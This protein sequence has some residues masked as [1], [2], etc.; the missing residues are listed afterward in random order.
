MKKH[1][2]KKVL[3]FYDQIEQVIMLYGNDDTKDKLD[4]VK[5]FIKENFQIEEFDNSYLKFERLHSKRLLWLL[6]SLINNYETLKQNPKEQIS[7]LNGLGESTYQK[8]KIL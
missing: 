3:L 6:F 5:N 4:F 7:K 2:R 1:K 8:M